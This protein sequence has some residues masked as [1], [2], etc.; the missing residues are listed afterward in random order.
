MYHILHMLCLSL[1][2]LSGDSVCCS[3]T[4][5]AAVASNSAAAV[6]PGV[7]LIYIYFILNACCINKGAGNHTRT[8]THILYLLCAR[9]QVC[10]CV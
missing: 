5:A 8:H 10:V 3:E 1:Y 2:T 6:A 7:C 4:A 9:V